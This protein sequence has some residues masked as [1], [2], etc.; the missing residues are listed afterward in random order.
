M[1]LELARK[2][3]LARQ[4]AALRVTASQLSAIL[5]A[6]FAWNEDARWDDLV[7]LTLTLLDRVLGVQD[8][9]LAQILSEG[10]YDNPF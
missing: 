10:P 1:S 4:A 9:L 2:S 5:R 7:S 3:D 6:L 8:H